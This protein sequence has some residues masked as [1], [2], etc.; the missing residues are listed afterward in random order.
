MRPSLS[1]GNRLVLYLLAVAL[2]F[3]MLAIRF[4]LSVGFGQ[5]P[6]LILFMPVLI[7]V[8]MFGGLGPGLIATASAGLATGYFLIPPFGQFSIAENHDLFQWG[9]LM[10]SGVLISVLA[11]AHRR[12][13]QYEFERRSELEQAH[14]HLRENETRLHSIFNSILDATILTDTD[15]RIKQVNPAFTRMFGYTPEEAVGRGADFIYADPAD[16]VEQGHQ[17]YRLDPGGETAL[18]Q[19]C[20]R[21]KDGSLFLAETSGA[22]ILAPDGSVMGF[23]SVHRDITE[24]K[25]AEQALAEAQAAALRQ[26]KAA[27][28]AALNRMEEADAVRREAE[29]SK[30]QLEA[31]MA[32][33]S[34]AVFI[35]DRDG[36]F[37]HLNDAFAAYHR[38]KNKAEC[39]KI[40]TE[41]PDIL[42]VYL[43][44]GEPAPI[45]QWAVSRALRGETAVDQEY[46]LR[47]K[48]SGETWIGC[49][50]L[51]PIRDKDGN[52]VGSVVTARDITERKTVERELHDALEEQRM[53]RLASLSLMED[54]MDAKQAVE[55]A[56]Q[57]LRQL[58]MA[59]E[60]S[61]ESIVITDVDANI[62]YVNHSFLRQTGYARDEVMGR[63]PRLLQ[64]GGTSRETFV[65]LWKELGQGSSWK[66]EFHNRR[67]DG[68]EYVNFTLIAPIRQSDGTITHYVGIQED[69]TEKKRIAEELD[70][71]RH[72]LEQ[73]VSERTHQLEVAKIAAEAANVAKSFFLANMSH[74]IRTPMNAILGLTHLLRREGV[75]PHQDERLSKIEGASQ[76]LLS[77]INDVLDLSKIEAG[78]IQLENRD[79]HLFDILDHVRS[80]IAGQAA[81]KGLIIDVDS[82][83][84]PIWLRGDPTRLRQAVLNYASNAVKFTER[85]RVVLRAKLLEDDGDRLLLRFEVE[86]T[87]IGIPPE[88]R[89]RLF[90]VFEQADASTTRKYGGTGLG[91]AITR[92]LA[93]LMGGE[94]GVEST[95]GVGSLFWLT[96]RVEHG[97]G[98]MVPSAGQTFKD[99]ETAL[100][101]EKAGARVLLAEDNP[102]NREVAVELLHA[103]ELFVETAEDGLV[104]L[105]KARTGN[106]DLILMDMQM[107]VMDG[108]SAARAIRALPGWG[109]K[110][111]LAMTAN[112][113]D[114]DRLAC[115]AADMN[116]FIPKPVDP[117][118][119]YA[120]LLRW[121]PAMARTTQTL[122][123]AAVEPLTMLAGIPGLNAELGLKLLSGRRETYLRLLRRLATDHV[124]DMTQLRAAIVAG[125]KD[126]A[127][128]I[129][130][131][132]KGSAGNLGATEVQRLAGE[133]DA[134]FKAGLGGDELERHIA[135]LDDALRSL[136][137]A[138]MEALPDN[139]TRQHGDID[140][141]EA[142]SVLLELHQLLD[143]GDLMACKLVEKHAPMLK[144]V[145]GAHAAELERQ[146]MNFEYNE[147]LD[148]LQRAR[149]DNPHLSV[150]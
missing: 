84:V 86:D 68:S 66:G 95:V 117:E 118:Q 129:A 126:Q 30:A 19:I 23:I 143:V 142:R 27:R 20:Y 98:V 150:G 53:A 136:A 48:D 134:A 112:A 82:D 39:S 8:A 100:R 63:N 120:V 128:R 10:L 127:R 148:I 50:N 44:D 4:Q 76:H 77:I 131:T 2:P 125:K 45:E 29:A 37:I 138:V 73:L 56:A 115:K 105:E 32:A 28:L 15:R 38:F 107:P 11:E 83:A 36:R 104:A 91:L 80:L 99:A 141:N 55:Q 93:Q 146:V 40:I 35:S 111:I 6:L 96:V 135:P 132:L 16:F 64:S 59:V 102:V 12:A 140:W 21:R 110:P 74:E 119:L 52:I 124:E 5:R 97:H 69:I 22:R 144:V 116:D 14:G 17:R 123:A 114:E 57:E 43:P 133:L 79:F 81:A 58:S 25:R 149:Q 9:M 137:C 75:T 18:I 31:A 109:V 7:V 54:A 47:R 106:Y 130:H 101:G 90:Q 3:I 62:V 113:Y 60:Q 70:Q 61:P 94:T 71:H 147:A 33:M 1:L 42:E 103:V 121:L 65:K 13:R 108:L 46:S 26:Q 51:A 49:Y 139:E 88:K 85:G 87:G 92:H 24:R 89:L 78:R 145:L 41:Y 67:K 34:D 122:P 72:H